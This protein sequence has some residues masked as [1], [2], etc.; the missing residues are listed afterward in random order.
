MIV[1][2]SALLA[3]ILSEPEERSFSMAIYAA[4]GAWMSTASY[5]EVA[6]KI[7][8]REVGLDPVLDA[9]LENLGIAL[10]PVT[11]EH[12]RLAR[13]ANI[14]FGRRHPAKLNFGDCLTYALAKSRDEPL[15]FKGDDFGMTDLA[16]VTFEDE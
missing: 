12:G 7:D 14:A 13:T 4:G 3:I 5:L 16:L 15:L 8:T 2:S 10:V 9:T 6:L 1:D 11:A